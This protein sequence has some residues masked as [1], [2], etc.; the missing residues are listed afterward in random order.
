MW[1]IGENDQ[2]LDD[3]QL[4]IFFNEMKTVKHKKWVTVE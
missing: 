4:R 3:G 2:V 1:F